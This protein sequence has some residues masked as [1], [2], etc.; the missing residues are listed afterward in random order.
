LNL[1]FFIARRYF[2][3]KKKKTFIN[4][5][6]IISMLVVAVGT[7]ALVIVLSVFNGLEDLIRSLY[8]TFDAELRIVAA[9]GK[10]FELSDS[11]RRAVEETEGVLLIT[12]V[13]EDNALIRYQDNEKVVKIKGVSRNFLD[14]HRLDNALLHGSLN[15][16]QGEAPRAILGSGVRNQLG[17]A[18]E[19][20]FYALR[21]YYPRNVRPGT[22]DPSKYYNQQNIKPGGI[23]SIEKQYD[24]NYVIVP[25]EF[26][27]RLFEYGEKRTALEIQTTPE[28]SIKDVQAALR[29]RLGAA[30]LVQNS[31]E[32][33]SSLLKAIKIEK[34]FVYI[35]FTFILAI[36]SF[37]IFFSLT[38]LAI[39]KKKDIAILFSQ[40][41]SP[42]LV[43]WIFLY[44]GA[45]IAFSGALMGIG[46]GVIICLIQQEYGL[47]SMGMQTSVNNAYPVKLAVSDLFFTALSTVLITLLAS[48]R[49]AG[50][51]ART[52][53]ALHI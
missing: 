7:M 29:Q 9:E 17:V 36:A 10:S 19:N 24:D 25:L 23:F 11:L 38:M 1:P 13:V 2:R 44:E 21:V 43:R 52:R 51:A 5:I 42:R 48:F 40:G 50:L 53:L 20:D 8:N 3:S 27:L 31:D 12:E 30:F 4:I 45:I 41:A 49:P 39:D 6:S 26:A 33:H 22:L 14:Q 47:V 32:Q 28:A 34:L 18:L 35:A 16:Y 15:L 46:L 37:N